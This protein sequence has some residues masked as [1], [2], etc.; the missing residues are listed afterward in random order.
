MRYFLIALTSLMLIA[1]AGCG[2][3]DEDPTGAGA[4]TQE[5][6]R[7]PAQ[8]PSSILNGA[9]TTMR[10]LGLGAAGKLDE[11]SEDDLRPSER[12][13]ELLID[14]GL[15]DEDR[16]CTADM[17]VVEA[18]ATREARSRFASGW[19]AG[20]PAELDDRGTAM[21]QA[22]SARCSER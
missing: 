9:L 20:A 12:G 4:I 21:Y 10:Q 15:V 11:V 18:E 13:A 6:G 8:A 7:S 3:D 22:L 16:F 1:A 2:S 14:R 19:R 5:E 17:I